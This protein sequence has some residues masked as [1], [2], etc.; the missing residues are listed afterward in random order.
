M[1]T[2]QLLKNARDVVTFSMIVVC[3]SLT[4]VMGSF[5]FKLSE[6]CNFLGEK[7]TWRK[8]TS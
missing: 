1:S 2:S 4:M 6:C 8:R 7:L 3:Y 5:L